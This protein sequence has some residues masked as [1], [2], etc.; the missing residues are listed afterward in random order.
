VSRNTA[1]VIPCQEAYP[2]VAHAR[3]AP[4]WVC[5]IPDLVAEVVSSGDCAMEIAETVRMWLDAGVQLVWVLHPP[6]RIV[7]VHRPGQPA[8]VL[9]DGDTLDGLDIVPGFARPVADIFA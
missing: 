7:V 6:R 1:D 4:G 5:V 9:R 3:G 8:R 2:L